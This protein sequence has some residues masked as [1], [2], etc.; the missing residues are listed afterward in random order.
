VRVW[1]LEVISSLGG[2]EKLP[3]MKQTGTDV[4]QESTEVPLQLKLAPKRPKCN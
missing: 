4:P 1:G 3:N 2:V